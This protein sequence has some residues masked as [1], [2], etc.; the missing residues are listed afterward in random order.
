MFLETLGAFPVFIEN[1]DSGALLGAVQDI[2]NA[3]W[4]P[5]SRGDGVVP[6]WVGPFTTVTFFTCSSAISSFCSFVNFDTFGMASSVLWGRDRLRPTASAGPG[7]FLV[8][9][10]QVSRFLRGAL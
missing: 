9:P 8:P 6:P 5:M 10:D 7:P 3:A 1:E 4:L 2:V